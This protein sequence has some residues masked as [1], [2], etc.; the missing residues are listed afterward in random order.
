MLMLLTGLFSGLETAVISVNRL[1]LKNMEEA[2]LSKAKVL[3]S[4][5]SNPH[6]LIDAMLMGTNLCML[7]A[8]AVSTSLMNH[9]FNFSGTELEF[10]N[11]VILTPVILVFSEVIPKTI[12]RINANKLSLKFSAYLDFFYNFFYPLTVFIEGFSSLFFKSL[13][14]I[15]FSAQRHVV[16]KEELQ[17]LLKM[18]VKDGALD[19]VEHRILFGI[20]GFSKK[21]AREIM[22]PRV[23]VKGIE[24]NSPLARIA[25]TSLDTGFSRFPVYEGELDQIKGIVYVMDLIHQSGKNP[26]LKVSEILRETLLVPENKKITEIMTEMK[27]RKL[28]LVVVIDEYGGMAGII[29]MDDILEEIFGE[30]MDEFDREEPDFLPL[31]HDKILVNA[32]VSIEEINNNL[33]FAIPDSDEYETLAGYLFMKFGYVPKKGEQIVIG[34]VGRI[35]IF[36]A[37]TSSIR[38][39]ILE[40][41]KDLQQ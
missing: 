8:A 25:K 36:D 6:K 41:F 10:Y 24:I 7:G 11:T 28:H 35:E 38:K 1:R 19:K 12:F 22:T 29:T 26:E 33:D 39:V 4:L 34:G 32:R 23:D 3:N 20:M 17:M 9:V 27:K 40:K 14:E 2:G 30:L 31:D 13:K 21:E 15:E 18:G 5:L 37:N 16:T